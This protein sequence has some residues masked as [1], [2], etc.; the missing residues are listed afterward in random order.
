MSI[1]AVDNLNKKFE[2]NVLTQQM[3][4][5]EKCEH[6]DSIN[7]D[8]LIGL[9]TCLE[10][11]DFKNINILVAQLIKSNTEILLHLG[12][13]K[14]AIVKYEEQVLAE[15]KRFN[16]N[17]SFGKGIL[18]WTVEMNQVFNIEV[19]EALIADLTFTMEKYDEFA[20]KY[21]N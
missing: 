8:L 21:W 10:M 15:E 18:R 9:A 4:M 17:E 1:R 12:N 19:V 6:F 11:Q 7:K 2:K 5:T 16:S 3:K 14:K 13:L 20:K